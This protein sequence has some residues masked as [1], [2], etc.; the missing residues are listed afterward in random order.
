[1]ELIKDNILPRLTQL[2]EEM[3]MLREVTWPVCQGLREKHGI[4]QYLKEKR[5][6]FSLLFREECVKLLRLKAEF[7]GISDPIIMDQELN[8]ICVHRIHSD[9]SVSV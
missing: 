1:M 8:S 2:E 9:G 3:R 5:I 4:F 7:L 6:F